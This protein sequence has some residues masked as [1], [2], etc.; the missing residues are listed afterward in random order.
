MNKI[1]IVAIL[2]II[3]LVLTLTILHNN[4]SSLNVCRYLIPTKDSSNDYFSYYCNKCG[5][6]GFEKTGISIQVTDKQMEVCNSSQP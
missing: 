4:R 1:R 6:E 5:C 3:G 2:V